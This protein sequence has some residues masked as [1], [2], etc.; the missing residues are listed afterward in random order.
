VLAPDLH[1]FGESRFVKTPTREQASTDGMMRAIDD[2]R[3]LL[4]LGAIPTALVGHSMAGLALLSHTDAET[5]VRVSRIAINPLLAPYDPKVR[6]MLRR[7]A[8]MT[9]TFGRIGPLRRAVIRSMARRTV[10]IERM[11]TESAAMVAEQCSRLG[12]GEIVVTLRALASTP[13][14]RGAHQ[15]LA[16]V[17][18]M[19]DPWMIRDAFERAVADLGLVAEN[20]HRLPSGGHHPHL[21]NSDRPEHSA[22]NAH[23]IVRVIDAMLVTAAEAAS[24]SSPLG[25]DSTVPISSTTSAAT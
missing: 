24:S 20:V 15:R 9:T 4:G 16:V 6:S 7:Q 14:V 13:A 17:A 5:G 1:G 22:R 12:A 10:E 2:W 11:S 25:F 18:C 3:R 8:M 21:E 23:D 19:D